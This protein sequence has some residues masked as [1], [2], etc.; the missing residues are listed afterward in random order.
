MSIP[1]DK[2]YHFIAGFV[3]CIFFS[4]VNDPY[5]GLGGAI[6]AGIFKECYDEYKQD[7]AFDW[8]DMIAT[9]I[10]GAC[11]FAL[12]SLLKYWGIT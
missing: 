12:V 11:G 5:T 9:W 3:I 7:G 1:Q 10:G 2:L 6:A 8:R 4:I